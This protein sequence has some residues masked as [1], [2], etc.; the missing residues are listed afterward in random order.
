[1]SPDRFETYA[2]LAWLSALRGDK[3]AADEL[4]LQAEELADGQ[5][6]G[7]WLVGFMYVNWILE[8]PDEIE[9]LSIQFYNLKA[10]DLLDPFA[11][12]Q[13]YAVLGDFDRGFTLLNQVVEEN[14]PAGILTGLAFSPAPATSISGAVTRVLTHCSRKYPPYQ[15]PTLSQCL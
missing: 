10:Q 3:K 1:M 8:R 13:G 6:Y 14:F 15:S 5:W 7:S 12:A 2:Q 4:L 9:R 11:L